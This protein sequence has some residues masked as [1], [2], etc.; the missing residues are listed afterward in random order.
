[1]AV[2][3]PNLANHILKDAKGAARVMR[4]FYERTKPFAQQVP[5]GFS[6]L[7]NTRA[8][9]RPAGITCP[10]PRKLRRGRK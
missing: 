4:L 10:I 5:L 7:P 1:M 9:T 8:E 6:C 3:T 2:I